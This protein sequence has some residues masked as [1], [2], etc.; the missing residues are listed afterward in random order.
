MGVN[1]HA[2]NTYIVLVC[3]RTLVNVLVKMRETVEQYLNEEFKLI[4]NLR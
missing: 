3:R 4:S 1:L 2:P